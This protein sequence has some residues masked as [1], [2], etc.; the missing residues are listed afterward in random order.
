MI[1]K[2]NKKLSNPFCVFKENSRIIKRMTPD[3]RLSRIR[4]NGVQIISYE[5]M[6]SP[7]G[8]SSPPSWGGAYLRVVPSPARGGAW[9][10]QRARIG[11]S[12]DVV[13]RL[14][15]PCEID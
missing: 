6:F 1:G 15:I 12:H 4:I 5:T 10:E 3:G 13:H 9:G 14:E 8:V 11:G 7:R 2:V